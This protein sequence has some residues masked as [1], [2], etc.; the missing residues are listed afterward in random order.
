MQLQDE[1]QAIGEI[2]GNELTIRAATSFLF[3][4][5]NAPDMLEKI[6]AC[7]NQ[8]AG[9]PMIV[10]VEE[11]KKEAVLQED[12]LDKLSQFGNVTFK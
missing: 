7:V 6:R 11:W 9:R 5:L 1:Y 10:R 8:C 12:K 2:S 3:N 4:N